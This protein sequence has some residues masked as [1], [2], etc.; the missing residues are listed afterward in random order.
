MA[1]TITNFKPATGSL[2][3]EKDMIIAN[4]QYIIDTASEDEM[5]NYRNSLQ[6]LGRV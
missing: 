1:D 3:K 6:S 2:P 4:L 5:V